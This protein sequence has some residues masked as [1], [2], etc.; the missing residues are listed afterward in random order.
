MANEKIYKNKNMIR[1]KFNVRRVI[2]FEGLVELERFVKLYE[3]VIDRY[4]LRKEGDRISIWLLLPK[5]DFD[6]IVKSIGLINV[7]STRSKTMYCR[8]EGAA[9]Y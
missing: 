4:G 1:T 7:K 9:V 6:E 3:D 2:Y 8:T 5:K